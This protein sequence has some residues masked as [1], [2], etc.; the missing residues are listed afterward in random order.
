[1][2]SGTDLSVYIAQCSWMKRMLTTYQLLPWSPECLSAD[3]PSLAF[4]WS[5]IPQRWRLRWMGFTSRCIMNRLQ[6]TESSP[7]YSKQKCWP[8]HTM[9]YSHICSTFSLRSTNSS[10]IVICPM[11]WPWP[12][13]SLDCS[14]SINS[15]TTS[16]WALPSDT[17]LMCYT[18]LQKWIF[19]NL[20]SR[21]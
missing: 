12:G 18:A 11:N 8:L 15:L 3:L 17:S 20:G 16:Y 13:T 6:S 9:R 7:C 10:K 1:M 14:S 2:I 5:V 4:W 21:H 19:S